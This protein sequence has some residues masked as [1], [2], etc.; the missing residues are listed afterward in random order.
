M[1]IKHLLPL[2]AAALATGA[3]HA[4]ELTVEVRDVEARGG[5]LYISIQAEDEF[6]SDRATASRRIEDPAAGDHRFRFNV[7]EGV[8]AVSIWHDDDDNGVFDRNAYGMPADGWAMYRGLELRGAPTFPDISLEVGPGGAE[9]S[10]RITY[11]R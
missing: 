1:P 7:P 3:A 9:V 11:G 5:A 10:E 6:M 4:G 2:C 8:Y